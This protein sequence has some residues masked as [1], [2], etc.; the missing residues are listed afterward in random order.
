MQ[1]SKN[2]HFVEGETTKGR[3]HG[4][5]EDYDRGDK[6]VCESTLSLLSLSIASHQQLEGDNK[7]LKTKCGKL[8]LENDQFKKPV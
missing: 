8:Q 5:S 2:I 7:Q 3:S 4:A 1:G 6:K